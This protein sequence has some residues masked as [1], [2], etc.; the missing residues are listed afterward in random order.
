[1]EIQFA[2][3]FSILCNEKEQLFTSPRPIHTYGNQATLKPNLPDAQQHAIIYTSDTPPDE[4]WYEA[5]DGS[6]VREELTKDPIKV[7]RERNDSDGDL[8]RASRINY[9]KIYTIEHYQ[10]VLNIGKVADWCIPSLQRNSLVQR[11]SAP[12]RP[13]PRPS[14]SS[15]DDRKGDQDKHR[16]RHP[17]RS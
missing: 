17:R 15:K 2:R 16:S 13:K 14:R 10:R 1:M 6:E 5:D 12:E 3:K 4:Y 9:S 11:E 7:N 8:G